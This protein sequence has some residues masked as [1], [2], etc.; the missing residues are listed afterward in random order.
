MLD[1]LRMF[2]RYASGLSA[3]FRD[4]VSFD[5]SR[6]R[7]ISS[8]ERREQSLLDTLRRGVWQ[9]SAS[10]YLPLFRR[11]GIEYAD[12]EALVH[13]EGVDRS[14]SELLNAGVYVTLDEFKGK[15]PIIRPGLEIPVTHEDFDNPLLVAHFEGK[16]GGSGGTRRRLL[17]DLGLIDQDA[18]AHAVFLD[19]FGL[20]GRPSGV[21]RTVPP[22]NSGIKKPL[23]SARLGLQIDRW[24]SQLP[25]SW[26]PSEVKYAAFTAFTVAMAR[27][28]GRQFPYPEYLPAANVGVIVEWMAKLAA[29]GSP[30]FFD[31]SASSAV[32]IC[33]Y[34]SQHNLNIDG[35]VFRAGSE[36]LTPA[37]AAIIEQAGVR[38]MA[39]Y[40]TS[41]TGPIGMACAEG[42]VHDDSHVLLGKMAVIHRNGLPTSDSRQKVLHLTTLGSTCPKLM[43]NV[44]TGDS[45]NIDFRQCG[46]G[47]GKLGYHQHISEIRSY[48]KLTSEGILLSGGD[49]LNL[50]EVALPAAFGGS[51]TDYQLVEDDHNGLPR[52]RIL[53][54]PSRGPIDE[55]LILRIVLEAIHAAGAGGRLM[56]AQLRDAGTFAVLRRE[57]YQTAAAKVMPLFVIREK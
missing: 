14:L 49:I 33:A 26:A 29:S 36:P 43:L 56:S 3:F 40:A 5:E 47:F 20:R 37:R 53:V 35:S 57:P 46:C 24:F 18:S 48:E 31:T 39:H 7:L 54:S 44:D 19:S 42:H 11:A 55:S 2:G 32:R 28:R 51:P 12:L 52:V 23:M 15:K 30:V 22:N 16:T 9:N 13:R 45:A 38:V 6:K 17:I 25:T 4:T 1:E 10:P 34:A 50:V 27:L 41:E 21:W 8:L